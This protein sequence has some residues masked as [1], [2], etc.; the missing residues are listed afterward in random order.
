MDRVLNEI[1]AMRADMAR[2]Q[3]TNTAQM[4][5]MREESAAQMERMMAELKKIDARREKY[6]NIA[7]EYT[8]NDMIVYT[9]QAFNAIADRVCER[10]KIEKTH[11]PDLIRNHRFR[12]H[13]KSK[14]FPY[15]ELSEFK[16][17]DPARNDVSHP[18][19]IPNDVHMDSMIAA[20]GMSDEEAVRWKKVFSTLE[21]M[22][23]KLKYPKDD[24]SDNQGLKKHRLRIANERA[25]AAL[26]GDLLVGVHALSRD[27][28]GKERTSWKHRSTLP[29]SASR[30]KIA[31]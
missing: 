14:G 28:V 9:F 6:D 21:Q 13:M 23:I 15:N 20:A 29:K 25:A 7:R 17:L 4:K 30:K 24:L 18:L 11:L 8:S 27:A 12:Q 2:M 3:E 10:F 22:N 1:L 26:N 16:Y 5:L 19:C 31:K